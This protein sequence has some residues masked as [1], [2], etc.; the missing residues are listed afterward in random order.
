MEAMAM[1]KPVVSTRIAGIPEL[2]DDE[3]TGL[4]VAPG[5]ADQLADAL[6]RLLADEQL[7]RAMGSAA[8][9]KVIREFNT[10]TSAEQLYALFLAQLVPEHA[11]PSSRRGAIPTFIGGS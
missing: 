6:G 7:R 11:R 9:E 8:R 5:R 2:I 3:H 4:L 1:E 10:E